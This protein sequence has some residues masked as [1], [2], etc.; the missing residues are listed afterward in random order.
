[1]F[2]EMMGVLPEVDDKV[3]GVCDVETNVH[4]DS[5]VLSVGHVILSVGV[6]GLVYLEVDCEKVNVDEE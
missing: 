1:M 3:D 6:V 2:G 4:V 5:V